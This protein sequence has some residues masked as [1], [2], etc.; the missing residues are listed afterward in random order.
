M[1]IICAELAKTYNSTSETRPGSR[2]ID[3]RREDAN[4]EHIVAPRPS[5]VGCFIP[6]PSELWE[7]PEVGLGLFSP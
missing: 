6:K 3:P 4:N 7:D 1:I 5:I 2:H